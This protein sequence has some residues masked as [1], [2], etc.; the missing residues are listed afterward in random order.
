MVLQ[1]ATRRVVEDAV[2]VEEK[3][4]LRPTNTDRYGPVLHEHL[5]NEATHFA[6]QHADGQ[7]T[8]V[9]YTADRR[10]K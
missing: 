5:A 3:A 9:P 4:T 2:R 1:R 10:V 7:G 6:A 8:A